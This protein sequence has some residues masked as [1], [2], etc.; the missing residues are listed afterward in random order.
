VCTAE[1]QGLPLGFGFVYVN[2]CL[3]VSQKLH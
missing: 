1:V 2:Y 3:V